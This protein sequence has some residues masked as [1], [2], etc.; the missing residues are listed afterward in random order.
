MKT[1]ILLILTIQAHALL[2]PLAHATA[3]ANTGIQ[4]NIHPIMDQEAYVKLNCVG[5]TTPG[6]NGDPVV[7]TTLLSVY[8]PASVNA[9]F[10][11]IYELRNANPDRFTYI[12]EECN[13]RRYARTTF[14]SGKPAIWPD[15]TNDRKYQ[16]IQ[17]SEALY[18]ARLPRGTGEG[19]VANSQC[20]SNSCDIAYTNSCLQGR[21]NPVNNGVPSNL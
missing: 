1:L 18:T 4:A 12:L 11:S 3:I 9:P 21:I 6:G 13:K 19:C 2:T 17:I 7:F 14:P 10:P 15:W 16:K 8:F 20:Q 5:I